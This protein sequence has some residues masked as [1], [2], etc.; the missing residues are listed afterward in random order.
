VSCVFI[1]TFAKGY[2]NDHPDNGQVEGQLK[3]ERHEAEWR[4]PGSAAL[5]HPGPSMTIIKM[6]KKKYVISTCVINL[7][8]L[9]LSIKVYV[10]SE[11]I[12]W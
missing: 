8:R 6:Y 9:T 11:A 7:M 10:Y 4:R 3:L 5:Q 2:E 1:D 12:S